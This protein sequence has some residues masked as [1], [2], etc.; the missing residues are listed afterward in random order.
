MNEWW[1]YEQLPSRWPYDWS[2]ATRGD[3][4]WDQL[5]FHLDL[6][7]GRVPK[8]RLGID[9]KFSE[10][11]TDL[12]IDLE[13]MFVYI[14]ESERA[15]HDLNQLLATPHEKR[16]P[17]PTGSIESIVTHHCFEHIGPGFERL[18]EECYRVLKWGGVMRVVTP[19]FPSTAAVSEYDH[20]RY[21][22]P[23]TLMGFC[24]ELPGGASIYD[25]FAERYNSCCFRQIDE[26]VS[27]PT[28]VDKQWTSEDVREIRTTL[29]KH[30]D[31]ED[32]PEP[33][34][35]IPEEKN[36]FS[37]I[38]AGQ[39]GD[40]RG[41]DDGVSSSEAGG[42]HQSPGESPQ[43]DGG[44]GDQ[45]NLQETTDPQGGTGAPGSGSGPSPFASVCVL[46]Y[47]RLS[48]LRECIGS[49][50]AGAHS[51]FE[52][53]VHDD[54]SRDPELR[55]W[56]LQMSE[57]GVISTLLM[58]SPGWNE[59]QGIAMNRMAAV[60]KGDPIIK[61]DQDLVFEAGWLLKVQEV[62]RG[63]MV[64]THEN[65]EPVIGALGIFKYPVDPVDHQKMF[66][67]DWG[68]FDE[69]ED[70]VG[71]LIAMPRMAW[72][73]WGPWDERSSAFAEDAIFKQTL[74]RAEGWCCALTKEDLARNQGFGV[75]PSTVVV[76]EGTVQ[77]IKTGPKVIEPG[78]IQ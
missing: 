3:R 61:C 71:S 24:Q 10:G 34:D 59:G 7:C 66:L 14:M 77:E 39:S 18:M 21:F 17:F 15:G 69:V 65:G 16:L 45:A 32:E 76:A 20:K 55:Q 31:G 68:G 72:E 22:M 33:S 60:A 28:P 63:N 12:V 25:A 52:L 19:V 26:E 37:P 1:R 29:W 51:P 67:K 8:G 78:V 2:P 49:M 53:I 9:R 35:F 47:E 27:P 4:P 73:I 57:E 46:S 40:I 42:D 38:Q 48:L 62:L 56:L 30:G 23:G 75:G 6:G 54:G 36:D 41:D 43:T 70:F 5:D 11:A 13:E 64:A 44:D 50:L 58:N 74:H